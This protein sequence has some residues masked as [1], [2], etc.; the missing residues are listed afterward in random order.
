MHMDESK[1]AIPSSQFPL[2]S[3]SSRTSADIDPAAARSDER[4]A[5]RRQDCSGPTP[6]GGNDC[7]DE[8]LVAVYH[9]NGEEV[10]QGFLIALRAMGIAGFDQLPEPAEPLE[11]DSVTVFDQITHGE[12]K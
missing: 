3:A 7:S 4:V 11:S 10:R 1:P 8:S 12:A 5:G 6:P 9:R 2:W